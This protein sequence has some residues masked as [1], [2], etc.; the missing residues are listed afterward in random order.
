MS[1]NT[2]G[3]LSTLF[4]RNPRL[5]VLVIGLVIVAGLNA[6][7]IL[8]R[9]EDPILTGRFVTINIIYPGA[10]AER[11]EALVTEPVEDSVRDIKEIKDIWTTSRVGY[12]GIGIELQE[13]VMDV[14][15]IWSRIRDEINDAHALMPEGVGAPDYET[16]LP[17]AEAM[18]VGISWVDPDSPPSETILSRLSLDLKDKMEQVSGTK[19]VDLYGEPDE[20]ITVTYEPELLSA[21]GLTPKDVSDAISAS[22]VKS[23]SGTLRSSE[24]QLA[25][26]VEG[27]LAGVDRVRGV[28]VRQMAD[29]G[30]LRV[31]D[32]ARVNKGAK[33][34]AS[35]I[36]LV[37][38]K[39]GVMLGARM[40][41][42]RRVDLWAK[43]ALATVNAFIADAPRSVKV[44]V[45]FD[46]S[47]FTQERLES[48]ALNLVLGVLLVMVVLLVMMGWRSA[49]L[50]GSSLPLTVLTVIFLFNVLDMP[51]HQIS[52]TGL[53]IALGLLIDNAIVA[54]DEYDR[55]RAKGHGVM[56]SVTLLVHH[57]AVPLGAST[58]TT[59]LTF[60]PMVLMPGAT[61][62][63]VWT[64][65]VSVMLAVL[66]SLFF[67][68]TIV[69]ALAGF[70][71]RKGVLREDEAAQHRAGY[72]NARL[73]AGYRR[74][75]DWCLSHPWKA[76]GLSAAPAFA[77]FILAPT[78]AGQFFPP[79]DR[80]QFQMQLS[81]PAQSS[82]ENTHRAVDV[83]RATLAS[84]PEV[85]DSHWV[86]GG[87]PPKVFYNTIFK[88]D[89]NPANAAGFVNT[90]S[91]EATRA[92][93]PRLQRDLMDRLPEAQILSIPFEQGP[94]FDAPIEVELYGPDLKT[95]TELGEEVRVILAGTDGVTYTQTTL[96]GGRPQLSVILDEDE[97]LASGRT[98]GQVA[99]AL[100][101]RQDGVLGGT[102]MEGL[103]ELP[104]LVRAEDGARGSLD[105]LREA[106]LPQP[107]ENQ[108]AAAAQG[109][110]S[111]PLSALGRVELVPSIASIPRYQGER[112]NRVQGFLIPF[113]LPS[114]SLADFKRRFDAS[115]VTIPAGYR[116]SFG[117]ESKESAKSQ[118]KLAATLGPLLVVMMGVLVLA[119][120]SFRQAGLIGLIAFLSMGM[121]LLSVWIFGFPMGF[122]VLVGGMGL[123]GISIND[124]I[125]VLSALR[126]NPDAMH[127]DRTATREVVVEGSR[128][129]L[130]TTLTTVG[131]FIP[132]LISGGSFWRPLATAITG[133]MV[134]STALALIFVPA[135]FLLMVGR[136]KKSKGTALVP[137]ARE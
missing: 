136:G 37:R 59:I 71:D 130:S 17:E 52:V 34:P 75:L 35:E 30:Y 74:F 131:G 103:V 104:V 12:S 44:E 86:V 60:A 72:S 93:L 11:V 95:L 4:A 112:Q 134:G 105:A 46:Q 76:A 68:L 102:V 111:V 84:Y 70:M 36:A 106:P 114:Q 23:P 61:G 7:S 78:L 48:L 87:N 56:E 107:G 89:S 21:L 125:V 15:P 117:G 49:L 6:L 123:I 32:V 53:I 128:H 126:A 2:T 47:I 132:L 137:L 85:V 43:D 97:T 22:D 65:G 67:A 45:L 90:V 64:L 118:G 99:Q 81:M 98:M 29:G 57:L 122:M 100:N 77:G 1:R 27:A 129:V 88:S 119:F 16:V 108:R 116:L 92:I 83:V 42:G 28:T 91:A 26:E 115:G 66:A 3:R 33:S 113:A 54:I 80:A 133:G 73:T 124:S 10:S 63:F 25:I 120:G 13:D 94:P 39:R 8:P 19:Q 41:S 96:V 5:V 40:E 109:G 82:L 127:G 110:S 14:D 135:V 101:M 121:A 38:G 9:Q 69:P 50:V 79:V 18:I 62:E 20:E 31:G 55:S 58:V 24:T 51:L